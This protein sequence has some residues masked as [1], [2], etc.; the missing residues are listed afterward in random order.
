MTPYEWSWMMICLGCFLAFI[1]ICVVINYEICES[2]KA[3][4][5]IQRE[6]E[7]RELFYRNALEVKRW[8]DSNDLG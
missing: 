7:K 8:R 1:G 6:K 2:R 4:K 3:K 5:N